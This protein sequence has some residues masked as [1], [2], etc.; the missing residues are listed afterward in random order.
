MDT[1][2]TFLCMIMHPRL[3]PGVL[4]DPGNPLRV[5]QLV[6]VGARELVIRAPASRP[7]GKIMGT[8][9]LAGIGQVTVEHLAGSTQRIEILRRS[10]WR[11]VL[12]GGIVLAYTL[13]FQ[14]Y[15]LH[16]AVLSAL[17]VAGFVVPLNFLL[18]G[19]LG[20]QRGVV[21]FHFFPTGEGRPF[22]LEVPPTREQELHEALS[23]AGLRPEDV[24]AT[25]L[26]WT[27]GDCGGIVD[28][29]AQSCPQCGAEFSD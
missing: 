3:F 28:A 10:L 26:T 17:A 23:A 9:P 21:R 5:Q 7:A 14:S 13:F 12:V 19:G 15:P 2:R 18:N 27:C 20:R 4:T 24:E 22:Y 6:E 11:M 29:A 8:E 25:Q 1:Q 16:Y